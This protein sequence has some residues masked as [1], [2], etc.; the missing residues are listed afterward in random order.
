MNKQEFLEAVKERLEGLPSQELETSLEYYREMIDDR[1]EDGMKEEEAVAA[2][3]SVEEAATQIL[4]GLPL[5]KIVKASVK[6]WRTLRVWEIVLLVV[7]APLWIPLL[8]SAALVFFAVYVVVGSLIFT[9]HAIDFSLALGGVAGIAG[10]ILQFVTGR[11]LGGG[12]YLGAGLFCAGLSILLFFAANYL[13]HAMIRGTK[14]FG[15]WVK[16][17]FLKHFGNRKASPMPQE[18]V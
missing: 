1:M 11:P 16:S 18:E 17:L 14:Q 3:G 10:A 15:L 5:P 13:D 12:M 9:L 6:P 2:I 4:G 7:G 8:I